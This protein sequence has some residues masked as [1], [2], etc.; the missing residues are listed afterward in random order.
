MESLEVEFIIVC[1]KCKSKELISDMF[2]AEIYCQEC[3]LVV[4]DMSSP[5]F[6][7]IREKKAVPRELT[8]YELYL[9][10]SS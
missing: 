1:P 9:T 8:G 6:K 4:M 2:H 5:R 10:E 7:D 3:G